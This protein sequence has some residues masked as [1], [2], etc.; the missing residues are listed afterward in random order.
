[1]NSK[2]KIRDAAAAAVATAG[3]VSRG[4]AAFPVRATGEVSGK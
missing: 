2:G 3:A 4:R 1:M